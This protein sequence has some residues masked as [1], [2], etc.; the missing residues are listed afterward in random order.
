M[1]LN[2]RQNNILKLLKQNN[3]MSVKNLAGKLFVSEMTVR[4]DLKEMEQSGYLR[5]YHGGAIYTSE[6]IM[7]I[8]ARKLTHLNQ[9]TLIMKSTEK[10][11]HDSMNIFLDSSSTCMY[12]IPLISEYSNMCIITNSVQ[13]VLLAAK[14]H[15]KCI[16]A[17]GDYFENDMCS[18]GCETERFL[19]N[20]NADAAF[21]SVQGF[22]DDNI[23]SDTDARQTAVRKIMLQNSDKKIL[24]IDRSK[25]HRKYLYTFCRGED[26]DEIVI[27]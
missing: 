14:Y 10:Y 7:P 17:G 13:N 5:R 15:I 22:S 16:L 8:K 6:F 19:K 27:V 12:I 26:V 20:I 1:I 9:K 23:A 18:V 2:E 21:F 4:R 24:I 11:L 3:S 25:L